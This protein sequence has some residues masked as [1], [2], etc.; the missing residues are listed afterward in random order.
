MSMQPVVD[1]DVAVIEYD[2]Y[3]ELWNKADE[4]FAEAIDLYKTVNAYP[5]TRSRE[6]SL[7]IINAQQALHWSQ[8][9]EEEGD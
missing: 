7:A 1:D 2:Q 6:L 3:I 9:A 4:T 8:N 5:G